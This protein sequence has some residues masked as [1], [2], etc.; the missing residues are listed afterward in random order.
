MLMS[1]QMMNC[2]LPPIQ[3]QSFSVSHGTEEPVSILLAEKQEV[4]AASC[5]KYRR[6]R[7]R[8]RPKTRSDCQLKIEDK[9]RVKDQQKCCSSD[10]FYKR[11]FHIKRTN[12]STEG[13]FFHITGIGK[14]FIKHHGT[15]QL[16]I[17]RWLASMLCSN[18][19]ATAFARRGLLS[20]QSLCPLWTGKAK[21]KSC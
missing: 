14:S 7:I 9:K 20:L 3:S 4:T 18:S 8:I 5:R 13:F 10:T 21:T 12:D 1:R 19:G 6:I 11:Y 16:A 15:S 2:S 17:W